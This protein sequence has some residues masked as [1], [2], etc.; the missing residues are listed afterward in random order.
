MS[1]DGPRFSCSLRSLL[2]FSFVFLSSLSCL[3]PSFFLLL[4]SFSILSKNDSYLLVLCI[5]VQLKVSS[6]VKGVELQPILPSSGTLFFGAP[7][8]RP[9]SSFFAK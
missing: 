8:V 7:R 1:K 9:V 5:M 4:S 6:K 2:P 3:L